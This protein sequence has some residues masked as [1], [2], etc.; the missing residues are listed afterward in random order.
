MERAVGCQPQGRYPPPKHDIATGV[1]DKE[2]RVVFHLPEP[3]PEYVRFELVPV[4]DFWGC[5]EQQDYS[6]NEVLRRGIAAG[7]K[8]KCEKINS[9]ALPQPGDVVIF[10]IKLTAWQKFVRELP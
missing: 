9:Q 7:Y 10:E 6:T 3:P 1:T 5:W 4:G 8:A 2:G